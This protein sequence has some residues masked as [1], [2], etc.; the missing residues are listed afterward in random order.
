MGCSGQLCV[1]KDETKGLMT[2]CEWRSSYGC[3]KKYSVCK[4]QKNGECDW[5]QTIALK[6]CL[7][8]FGWLN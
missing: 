1:D 8:S 3:L 6:L 5:T 7:K 4:K 2:T